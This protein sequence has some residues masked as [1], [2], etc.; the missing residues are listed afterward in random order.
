MCSAPSRSNEPIRVTR[1]LLAIIGGVGFAIGAAIAIT[2]HLS[3]PD[4]EVPKDV[5]WAA[6]RLDEIEASMRR[7]GKDETWP[8]TRAAL[9]HFA[10]RWGSAYLRACELPE[11]K[12]RDDAH[13]CTA[14]A[15]SRASTILDALRLLD[16][17]TIASAESSV[18]ALPTCD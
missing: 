13:A 11:G 5:P 1:K 16:P 6:G 2:Q 4:C 7:A 9:E 18:T 15:Y 3:G 14:D 17:E 10:T 12:P 8:P